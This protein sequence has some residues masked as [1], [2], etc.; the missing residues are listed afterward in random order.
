MADV[1]E[2]VEAVGVVEAVVVVVVVRG[3]A[4]IGYPCELCVRERR[5]EYEHWR[6]TVDAG[7]AC[8]QVLSMQIPSARVLTSVWLV[9]GEV[10]KVCSNGTN[11][12][13]HSGSRVP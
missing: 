7:D 10:F 12:Y 1:S 4:N 6:G 2:V 8:T 3:A 5:M 13:L 11:P 9:F